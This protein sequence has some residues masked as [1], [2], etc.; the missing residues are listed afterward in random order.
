MHQNTSS[1]SQARSFPQLRCQAFIGIR[2]FNDEVLVVCQQ[3]PKLMQR[4]N[5]RKGILI[6]IVH[7]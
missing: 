7:L 4:R 6:K 5:W 3:I 1:G 2:G